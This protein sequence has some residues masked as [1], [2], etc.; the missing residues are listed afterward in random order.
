MKRSELFK[1]G[2][3]LTI[4]LGLFAYVMY[5]LPAA[6]QEPFDPT[7]T[8]TGQQQCNIT[9]GDEPEPIVIE[10]GDVLTIRQTRKGLRLD[11]L[12]RKYLG[13]CTNASPGFEGVSCSFVS[14]GCAQLLEDFCELV[15]AKVGRFVI[16]G[17]DTLSEVA[18]LATSSVT[19]SPTSEN[20]P[21][22]RAFGTC[23]WDYRRQPAE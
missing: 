15:I 16:P 23:T 21:P 7:G 11:N 17:A 2:T 10:P 6:A 20:G 1:V 5:P 14:R 12:D 22:A 3:I 19:V 8:Y 9:L 4:S 13:V 18:F